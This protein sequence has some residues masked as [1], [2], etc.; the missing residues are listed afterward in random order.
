MIDH[1]IACTLRPA[2]FENRGEAWRV[3]IEGWLIERQGVAGGVRLVFE[4]SP[5]VPEAAAEL[6]RLEAECCPW[7]LSRLRDDGQRLLMDLSADRPEAAAAIVA[8]FG[9]VEVWG[10][11]PA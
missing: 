10:G 6:L 5:G 9:G 4:R 2:E 11:S 3:L 1:P 8:L 7:M